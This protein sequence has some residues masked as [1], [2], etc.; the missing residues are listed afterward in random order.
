M[1]PD[2]GGHGSTRLACGVVASG[3]FAARLVELGL[4][5]MSHFELV[6][7]IVLE[8]CAELFEFRPR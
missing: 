1:W 5:L 8:L 3:D 6:F 7:Q 4:H 2:R